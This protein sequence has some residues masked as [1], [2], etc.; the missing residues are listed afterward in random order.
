[1]IQ[2]KP[3]KTFNIVHRKYHSSRNRKIQKNKIKKKPT[4]FSVA[5]S[6][7]MRTTNTKKN[8]LR[9]QC[10]RKR[11]HCKIN[12]RQQKLHCTLHH[13]HTGDFAGRIQFAYR[14]QFRRFAT[15]MRIRKLGQ[16]QTWRAKCNPA[17]VRTNQRKKPSV[18][19]EVTRPQPINHWYRWNR[20]NARGQSIFLFVDRTQ[21]WAIKHS[22]GFTSH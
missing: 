4:F 7:F 19:F 12:F 11:T 2:F 21:N 13:P 15:S 5:S 9:Q 3:K 22:L 8:A 14:R 17:N 20:R 10:Q 6:M 16:K 1:M 18:R